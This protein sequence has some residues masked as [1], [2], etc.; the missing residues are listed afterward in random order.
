ML[1]DAG[2][3]IV[4]VY[5]IEN[6]ANPPSV[7]VNLVRVATSVLVNLVRVVVSVLARVGR[8]ANVLVNVGRVGRVANVLVN[9]GRVGAGRAGRVVDQDRRV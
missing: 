3:N 6:N 2:Y 5:L 9:V 7:L 8:V 4:V 1:E